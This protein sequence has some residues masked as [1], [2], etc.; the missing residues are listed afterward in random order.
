MLVR[1]LY[2]RLQKADGLRHHG[3]GAEVRALHYR[4]ADVPFQGQDPLP[5]VCG[6]VEV[7]SEEEEQTRK[8][9]RVGSPGMY[10]PSFLRHLFCRLTVRIC[11]Q[12]VEEDPIR[13]RR[14][15]VLR[16]ALAGLPNGA[17]LI[18]RR[19]PSYVVD[20]RC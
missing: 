20:S 12:R 15:A 6:V 17:L 10:F 8:R 16:L 13:V 9:R 3:E 7:E 11:F 4:K 14:R 2:S 5:M 19:S 1:P 18:Q